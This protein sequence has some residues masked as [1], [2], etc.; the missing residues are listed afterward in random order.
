M[1]T[2]PAMSAYVGAYDDIIN[3]PVAQYMALSKQIGGDVLKHVSQSNP[4]HQT[5]PYF[6]PPAVA[7]RALLF[8]VTRQ[9]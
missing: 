5:V 4:S 3:G 2:P 1:A 9:T 8:A 7:K 6:G